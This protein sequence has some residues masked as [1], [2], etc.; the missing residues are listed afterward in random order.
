MA[1]QKAVLL[2][3]GPANRAPSADSG[4]TLNKQSYYGGEWEPGQLPCGVL[5]TKVNYDSPPYG[6]SSQVQN[7]TPR[8]PRK[9]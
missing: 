9:C 5:R 2:C 3:I 4:P 1:K 6:Q 7:P 8:S